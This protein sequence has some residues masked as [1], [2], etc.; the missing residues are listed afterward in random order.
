[1][2]GG[3][4]L[5]DGI[6]SMMGPGH[7]AFGL[8]DPAFGASH[9]S[10]WDGGGGGDLARQAGIDDIGRDPHAG[11]GG[12]GGLFG[13]FDDSTADE[14]ADDQADQDTD[15]FDVGDSDFGGGGDF[16]GSDA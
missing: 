15:G 11:G 7:G 2:I 4:L 12:G 1:V 13:L 16:G 10:P 6:R 14:A 5:L 8:A 9:G 3:S